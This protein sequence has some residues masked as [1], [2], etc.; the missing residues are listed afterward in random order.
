MIKVYKNLYFGLA[1]LACLCIL[2][3]VYFA[4]VGVFQD[5]TYWNIH[6]SFSLFKYIYLV[7]FIIGILGK[8]PKSLTWSALILFALTNVQYYTAHGFLASLHV[9]FPFIIF[10]LNLIII[11]NA[12]KH[13]KQD[14]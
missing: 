4:G 1:C 13:L 5:Y 14:V 6:K 9:V 3:Q 2:I 7:M 11:R 10:G 8:I 12:L